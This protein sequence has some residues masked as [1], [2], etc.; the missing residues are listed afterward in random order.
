ME[1]AAKDRRKSAPEVP[2][3]N[4]TV[5][6]TLLGQFTISFEGRSAGPWPRPS[7][8][9]LCELLMLR[10]DHRLVREI[11]REMLFPNLPGRASA[12]ALSKAVSLARQAVRPL[13][14][15]GPQLVQTGR[16][17]IYVPPE[18]VMEIDLVRHHDALCCALAMKP[19]E[20]RDTGLSAA[21]LENGVLLADEPYCDWALE[22]RDALELLRQRARLELARGRSR[23]YGS[24]HL[25]AVVDAWEMCLTHD[26][27]S[28]EAGISLMKAYAFRGQ[29]QLVVRT[30]RRCHKGLEELGLKPSSAMEKAFLNAINDVVE[31]ETPWPQKVFEW[32]GIQRAPLTRPGGAEMDE[33]DLFG[34]M[35]NR[36]A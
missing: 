2:V 12:R 1:R 21:L 7:A 4:A 16:D 28:E 9:R 25:D 8:R 10:P 11:V 24:T 20:A 30:Y 29:R 19:G 14:S 36:S 33:A 26:V 32:A 35:Q 17:H 31:P 5:T 3:H 6:V 27:A 22:A 18:T 13:G 23:G 15:G 34:S